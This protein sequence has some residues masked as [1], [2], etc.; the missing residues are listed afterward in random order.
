MPDLP[1]AVRSLRGAPLISGSAILSLGLAIGALTTIFSI[2]DSL[3][4]KPL[5][6]TAPDRL[7]IVGSEE[8]AEGLTVA[9]AVWRACRNLRLSDGAFAWT[10]DR[11]N[12]AGRGQVELADAIWA[13]GGAAMSMATP[14][15]PSGIRM[16]PEI[17]VPG[18]AHA[19]GTPDRI[20][21]N[22]VTPGWFRTFGTQVLAG[23][24]VDGRDRA[25]TTGVAIVNEAFARRYFG[26]ASPLNRT[27][28][29]RESSGERRPLVIVGLVQDAG[30]KAEGSP[31]SLAR[32]PARATARR[33]GKLETGNW[34]LA[35]GDWRLATGDWRLAI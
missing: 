11:V 23:R 25:G 18:S 7:A 22:P 20:L 17:A 3:L 32:D 12:L 1:D 34:R 28:V 27:I 33:E 13:S 8:S 9:Y 26:G 29:E 4:M 31:A 35:T 21:A 2:L 16:T 5:P 24:D 14:L 19:G 10:T 15:G 30:R 6:V